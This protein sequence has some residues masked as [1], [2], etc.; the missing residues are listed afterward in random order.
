VTVENKTLRVFDLVS[1]ATKTVYDAAGNIA[2][3]GDAAGADFDYLESS[4]PSTDIEFLT[5]ADYTLV[6]NK[7]KQPKL[8]T[9]TTAD[10]GVEGLVFL[11]Q[12]NYGTD[13]TIT[14]DDTVVSLKT[15]DATS[16]NEEYIQ[17]D[18]IMEVLRDWLTNGSAGQPGAG[19]A[20]RTGSVLDSADFDVSREGSTLWI[21]RD[22][23]AAFDLK[24]NDSV[25]SSVLKMAKGSV[26]SFTDLPTVAPNNFVI[27]VDG[28]PDQGLEGSAAY[29]AK[30][31]TVNTASTAFEDGE[32]EE[33]VAQGIEYKLEGSLM[34]HLL[35]RMSGGDFLWAEASGATVTIGANSPVEL[36]KWGEIGAGDTATNPLP[37]FVDTSSSSTADKVRGMSFYK[38]R[39]VI[40]AGETVTMSESGRYFNFFRTTVTT[41][42][43]SARISVVAAHTRVNLLNYAVP[44]R[45][46]LVLFS[47]FTQFILTGGQDGTITPT[48]ISVAP[49]SEYESTVGIKPVASKRSIFF[50]GTRGTN[51]TVRELYDASSNRPEY[52][53][54]DITGQAPSYLAG[55]TTR[56]D[57]SPT[58]DCLVVKA[59]ASNT[60]YVYKWFVNGGERQQSAWSKFTLSGSTPEVMH[61]EWVDQYLYIVVRRGSETSLERMDFEPFLSDTG[62]D[63]R[64]HL[65]RRVTDA[66]S[67]VTGTYTPGTNSTAF[68]LPYTA[69]TGA[70]PQV[71]TRASGGTKAG[72]TLPVTAS[73][74]T[75]V[76]VSGDHSATP[77]YIGE[78]YTLKYTFSELH[79]QQS[80]SSGYNAVPV[81]SASLRIRYGRLNYADS[82]YFK[83]SVTPTIGTSYDYKMTGPPLNEPGAVIG[84]VNLDTGVFSFPVMQ[85][86]DRVTIEVENDSPL[87]SRLTSCEWESDLHSRVGGRRRY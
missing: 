70:T 59:A 58:E 8:K 82:G 60:L 38:D 15:P 69:T 9:D 28:L 16:G 78:Q 47:E 26:Q 85:K 72:Q 53:A 13:Y 37:N 4:A 1:G 34:P 29:Y 73:T 84:S 76:T 32:W 33:T 45:G 22:N 81:V 54:V 41:V 27:K 48:N 86:H 65:D 18:A 46:N 20:S 50:V 66:H 19:V 23:G 75:T 49:T 25:G 21:K 68:S 6:L 36:P 11:S 10:R 30:F 17:T 44:L 83:V 40:L 74:T 62:A 67:G 24:V 55:A 5:I 51:T 79:L 52:E 77:V 35:V 39:L 57:A 7:T 63:F 71:V 56:M 12:G 2:A 3:F 43:D 87:P 64:V 80:G 31:E 14:V 61:F 42:L